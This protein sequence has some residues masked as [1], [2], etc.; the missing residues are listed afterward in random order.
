[1]LNILKSFKSLIS[2]NIQFNQTLWLSI[3]L[4]TWVEI[5]GL[6][7]S[8]LEILVTFTTVILADYFLTKYETWKSVFPFSWVNAWFWISFFLRSDDLILY[9]FAWLLAIFSKKIFTVVIWDKKRHFFNPSNF[10]VFITLVLF[11][12]VSWSNPLQWWQWVDFWFYIIAIILIFLVSANIEYRL[13]KILNFSLFD[14]IIPLLITHIL[15][16]TFFTFETIESAYLFFN[17]SFWIF[18]FFMVTDP[19]TIPTKSETRIYFWISISLLFFILQYFI[20]ENYSLLA[21]LFLMTMFLPL[22]WKLELNNS[23][24]SVNNKKIKWNIIHNKGLIIWNIL[25]NGFKLRLM[26]LTIIFSMVFLL[27]LLIYLY[28]YPDLVFNN[29]CNQLFCRNI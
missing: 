23:S 12:Y 6:N 14:L 25:H 29:R 21:S 28:W 24:D 15:I 10:W 4:I 17:W 13:K 16:F 7:I 19:R 2:W 5:Y 22:I 11:P 9:I 3:L 8:Y 27:A 26:M 1:M 20:N 18:L